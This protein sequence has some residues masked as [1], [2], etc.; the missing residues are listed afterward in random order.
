QRLEAVIERR[1]RGLGRVTLAPIGAAESP[2]DLGRRPTLGTMHADSADEHAIGFP[3]DG[4]QAETAQQP[5][6]SDV[7]HAAP[8]IG[9]RNRTTEEARDLGVGHHGG[10]GV[11]IVRAPGAKDEAF[12]FEGGNIRHF[13]LYLLS[14]PTPT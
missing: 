2:A 3:L 12:G 1:A 7:R 14:R 13:Y 6:T 5:M 8:P 9:P 4:P 10:V 11:E